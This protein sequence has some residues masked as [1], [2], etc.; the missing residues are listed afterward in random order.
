MVMNQVDPDTMVLNID[1]G[2]LKIHADEML[3][4]IIVLIE[5]HVNINAKFTVPYIK[6]KKITPFSFAITCRHTDIRIILLNA[7][8]DPNYN[9]HIL[10]SY[11]DFYENK[12]IVTIDTISP[13]CYFAAKNLNIE[14][15]KLIL[16]YTRIPVDK[17]EIKNTIKFINTRRED[18]TYS[19]ALYSNRISQSYINNIPIII[20]LLEDYIKIVY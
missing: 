7:G 6:N 3:K 11:Y 17:N 10:N 18:G 4:I 9:T 12:D 15:V 1:S 13:I 16:N 20:K 8:A 5:N 19:N 14:S 2:A